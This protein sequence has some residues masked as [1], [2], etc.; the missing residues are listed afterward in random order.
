MTSTETS[1]PNFTCAYQA[2]HWG[3]TSKSSKW[4][5][6]QLPPNFACVCLRKKES[7]EEKTSETI[8]SLLPSLLLG[9]TILPVYLHLPSRQNQCLLEAQASVWWSSPKSWLSPW[10]EA[11]YELRETLVSK[12]SVQRLLQDARFFIHTFYLPPPHPVEMENG[13]VVSSRAS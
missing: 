1:T 9:S 7:V 10:P 2:W 6:E 8:F 4:T 5:D 12:A 11:K 13:N 3:K